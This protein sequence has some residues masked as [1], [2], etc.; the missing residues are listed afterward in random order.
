M[1]SKLSDAQYT[2]AKTLALAHWMPLPLDPV[3]EKN[4]GKYLIL[5]PDNRLHIITPEGETKK[6]LVKELTRWEY[7]IY[8]MWIRLGGS[9]ED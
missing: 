8:R 7:G 2:K 1:S 9:D 4:H 3:D 5:S 6:Y